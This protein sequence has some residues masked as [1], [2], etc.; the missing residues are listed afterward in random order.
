MAGNNILSLLG[1]SFLPNLVTGWVQS[2]YYGLTIRAGDR[3]PA[4]GTPRYAEHRRR[5]HIL[6]VSL[7]LLYTIY[8]ADYELRRASS[9]YADLG[10]PFSA[11]ERDIKSRFRRL[12]ALH[13]P[14]KLM[15]SGGGLD[16]T[17]ADYFMHLKTASDTLVDPAR[18]F[19]YERFGPDI[20]NWKHCVTVSDYVVRGTQVLIPY[21][22]FAAVAMYVLGLL[23]YLDWGRYWRWLTLVVLC[24]FELHTVTRPSFPRFLEHVVNPILTRFTSHPPYLPFQAISLARKLSITLYI[25]FSQIGPLLQPPD[26]RGMKPGEASEKQL[27]QNLDRLEQTARSMDVDATRLMELEMSPFTGDPEVINSMRSKL[28]EWLVQ[29]TI[30]ADPMVKDALGRSFQKRRV[31]APAGAKGNR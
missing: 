8:E 31:D 30:R 6:V 26:Q 28:K 25:A 18:R 2:I 24:V 13:H 15:G 14:D 4:P 7:Y 10:V 23:G 11:T 16:S 17:D 20:V 12:A 19:A 9:Y 27:L 3:K 22:G 21:Y 1:W 29:N 5:I